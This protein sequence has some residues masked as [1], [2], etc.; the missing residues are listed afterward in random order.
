MSKRVSNFKI[1]QTYSNNWRNFHIDPL[2]G[3][4]EKSERNT[5]YGREKN[6]VVFMRVFFFF[7]LPIS[8]C[9]HKTFDRERLLREVF[10]TSAKLSLNRAGAGPS[11]SSS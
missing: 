1:R 4:L 8:C 5:R 6:C 3:R 11:H 9:L 7:Y 10:Q 2:K